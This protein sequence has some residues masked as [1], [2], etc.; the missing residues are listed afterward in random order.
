MSSTATTTNRRATVVGLGLIGGSICV[1]LRERGWLVSGDDQDAQRV[2]EALERGLISAAGID[3]ESQVTF[4]AV[5]VTAIS[6]QVQRALDATSGIVTDV[7]SVKAVVT[8]TITDPRFIGGHP[9]AGSEL[10]GLD[11]ADGELFTGAVWVL[12]PT[13]T[14][15]DA[16]FATVANIVNDLGAEVVGLDPVRHD[17]LVAIVSHVPHLTAATL[18]GVAGSRATEHAALLRL[19]AGG[20]RDMTRIASGHPAIWLDICAE[21]RPAIISTLSAL[22]D[23]LSDMRTAVDTGD[24]A[25]ILQRLTAARESRAN[26]PSR[27]KA[28]ADLSE[29]R[30]P[31]PDRP[32]A[33]AEVFTLAAEL[34]VN[35]PNFEVVHSV[36][37]DRGIAVVLVETTSVELFRGGLMARGFKPS[38][39]RLD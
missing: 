21:N 9:M 17:E 27:I 34:G 11:G 10:E 1:A 3:A 2:T 38:V 35:I 32:G 5:P 4:V 25:T 29:V 12:T 15:S 33:A 7:G 13:P 14:T 18:M 26:L 39:Q 22:I 30:I 31:I 37:G 24:R 6:L 28:L 8:R 23:G 19:A 20:F 16:A 36:E